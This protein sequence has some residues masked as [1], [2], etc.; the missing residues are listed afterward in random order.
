MGFNSRELFY[1]RKKEKT[2]NGKDFLMV[3]AMG[4]TAMT[5]LS[6]TK[7]SKSKIICLDGDGSF[8]M[9]MGALSM[10][11]NFK[12]KNFKYILVDNEAHESIGMQPI[13]I[14]KIDFKNLSKSLGFKN[15]YLIKEKK[16][17]KIK[18]S[19]FLKSQGPSFLHV[20]VK[21]GTIKNL[22]RPKDFLRIKKNFVRS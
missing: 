7:F 16:D 8:I 17:I 20:K 19:S 22:P 13:L 3:G 5:A 15:F 9:H 2:S 18:I 11:K 6:M 21:V 10:L 4:H 1:L 14:N 12:A